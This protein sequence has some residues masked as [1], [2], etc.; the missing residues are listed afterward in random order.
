MCGQDKQLKGSLCIARY[1]AEHQCNLWNNL[2]KRYLEENAP[3][4]L[5]TICPFV[6]WVKPLTSENLYQRR[7]SRFFVELMACAER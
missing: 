1:L 5:K 7:L 6:G 4:R 3:N 2:I